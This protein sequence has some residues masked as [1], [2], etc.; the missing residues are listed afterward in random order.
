MDQEE[1][2]LCTGFGNKVAV[3]LIR[4]Q[5]TRRQKRLGLGLFQ[6]SVNMLSTFICLHLLVSSL[7]L[8]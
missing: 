5:A 2:I 1:V 3:D 6:L 7:T 4:Q 8:P